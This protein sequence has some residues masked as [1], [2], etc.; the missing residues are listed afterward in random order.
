MSRIG[1]SGSTEEESANI[2]DEEH[3]RAGDRSRRGP[4]TRVRSWAR[5]RRRPRRTSS[6]FASLRMFCAADENRV[7]VLPNSYS[8]PG[9]QEREQPREQQ[10]SVAVGA[11]GVDQLRLELDPAEELALALDDADAADHGLLEHLGGDRLRRPAQ[12]H[13]ALERVDAAAAACTRR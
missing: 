6:T 10:P 11:R 9:L 3:E 8:A 13:G 4:A 2:A 5:S 12:Q 1:M 7:S